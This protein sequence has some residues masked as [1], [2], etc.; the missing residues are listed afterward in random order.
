MLP[1]AATSPLQPQGQPAGTI[2][3]LRLQAAPL[4]LPNPITACRLLLNPIPC[5]LRLFLTP[6]LQGVK[7][8]IILA[9]NKLGLFQQVSFR[10][11]SM[12]GVPKAEPTAGTTEVEAEKFSEI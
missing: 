3:L 7:P 1:A 4:F 8:L 10:F 11:L 5:G 12:C 9:G 6:T 2:G